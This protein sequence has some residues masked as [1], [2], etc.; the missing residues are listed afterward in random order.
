M[1]DLLASERKQTVLSKSDLN[2]GREE[3]YETQH[4]EVLIM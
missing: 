2:V 1:N 4:E 3:E